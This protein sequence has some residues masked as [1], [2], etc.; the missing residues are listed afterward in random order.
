ML[1]VTSRL[2][3]T[4][5]MPCNPLL[6]AHFSLPLHEAIPVWSPLSGQIH[7]WVHR[8]HPLVVRHCWPLLP[9]SLVYLSLLQLFL[10]PL[11]VL[12]AISPQSSHMAAVMLLQSVHTS[13]ALSNCHYRSYDSPISSKSKHLQANPHTCRQHLSSLHFRVAVYH[14]ISLHLKAMTVASAI[15]TAETEPC[16]T[17]L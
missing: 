14:L 5:S 17:L 16:L 15:L 12:T 9:F 3:S 8:H 13:R 2:M 4:Y 10:P 7:Q 11:P 6:E 1:T